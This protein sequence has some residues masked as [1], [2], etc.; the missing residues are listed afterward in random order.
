[1]NVVTYGKTT[2]SDVKCGL[3]LC[4]QVNLGIVFV[5]VKEEKESFKAP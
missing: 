4:V 1:M 3:F 2:L 5:M